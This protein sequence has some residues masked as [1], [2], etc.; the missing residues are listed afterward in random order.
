MINLFYSIKFK[1]FMSICF[2]VVLSM[3]VLGFINNEFI[4]SKLTEYEFDNAISKSNETK[5][6]IEYILDLIENTSSLLCNNKDIINGLTDKTNPDEEYSI[7][8]MLRNVSSIQPQINGIYIVGLNGKVFSSIPFKPDASILEKLDYMTGDD[9]QYSDIYR[10]SGNDQA[11]SISYYNK[12]RRYGVKIGTLIIDIDYNSLRDAFARTSIKNDEKVIVVDKKGGILFNF[13]NYVNL[14][15]IIENNPEIL[16]RQEVQI[17]N[18]V[19][20]LESIIVTSL[21]KNADWRIVRI[22][23]KEKVYADTESLKSLSFLIS[24][25]FVILTLGLCLVLKTWQIGRAHV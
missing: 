2:L 12:I 24:G 11:I 8:R 14:E 23:T 15:S 1:V 25:I 16:E 4:F 6:S 7:N 3:S 9:G 22:I 17:E 20:G 5:K 10:E 21:I 19:F 13:P 18:E